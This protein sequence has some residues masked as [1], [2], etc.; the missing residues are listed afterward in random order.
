MEKQ[1][2]V[3]HPRKYYFQK[4]KNSN[5]Y[6]HKPQQYSGQKRFL[7]KSFQ[8][9]LDEKLNF[10]HHVSSGILKVKKDFL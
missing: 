6:D 4:N 8:Y 1:I 5:S 2:L 7:S 10:K 9:L 3:N